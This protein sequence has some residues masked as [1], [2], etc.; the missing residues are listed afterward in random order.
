MLILVFII[1]Y[2][3]LIYDRLIL[4]FKVIYFRIY[5]NIL[6]YNT[7]SYTGLLIRVSKKCNGIR[8]RP[9]CEKKPGFDHQEKPHPD[10]NLDKQL[11]STSFLILSS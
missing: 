5:H 6:Q 10:P 2:T 8:I 3:K 7:A 4:C 1:H 11:R 9:S